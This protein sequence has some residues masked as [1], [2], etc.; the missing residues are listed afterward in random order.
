MIGGGKNFEIKSIMGNVGNKKS[1]IIIVGL[2]NSGKSTMINFLKPQKYRQ[3]ELAATVGFQVETFQR[4]KVNFT[5]FDMSGQ[6]RYRTLWEHYYA[7]S[8]AIIFVIDAADELRFAV[9]QNEL[10]ELL[11]HAGKFSLHHCVR[12]YLIC[13]RHPRTSATHSFLCKQVRLAERALTTRDSRS[14]ATG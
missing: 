2:D 10:Q 8:E 5:V 6:G 7:K 11:A 4:S 14:H 12:P 1:Q 3:Q 13:A 9:A